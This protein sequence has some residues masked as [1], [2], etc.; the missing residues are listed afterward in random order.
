MGT[1]CDAFAAPEGQPAPVGSSALAETRA[2]TR[3]SRTRKSHRSTKGMRA[4]DI[5]GKVWVGGGGRELAISDNKMDSE[6]Q[7]STQGGGL[8]ELGRS[9][10]CARQVM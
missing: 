1:P 7:H 10:A 6:T 4:Y 3:V 5:F 8:S 9:S 2:E